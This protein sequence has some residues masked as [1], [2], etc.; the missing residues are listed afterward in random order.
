MVGW[1][2]VAKPYNLVPASIVLGFWFLGIFLMAAKRFGEI[3]FIQNQEEAAKYR[4]SF[5]YYNEENLL[6]SMIAA[7]V[8]FSFMLGA[9][10]LKYSVDLIVALPFTVIWMIWFF[11]LAYQQNTI[12]KDPERIFE[13]KTFLLFSL[14]TLLVFM[15]FFFS[16]N[17]IFAWFLR[18]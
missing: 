11:H 2:A 12:V 16:G 7:A 1:Y 17:Q 18:K 3:R 14:L 10:S 9:L 8:S 4:K 5:K 13:K 6:F 15:Y